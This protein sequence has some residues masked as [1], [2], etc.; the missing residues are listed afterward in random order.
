MVSVVSG[1][2]RGVCAGI[3]GCGLLGW[4]LFSGGLFCG[5]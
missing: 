2:G 4:G 3:S 1:L 5:G